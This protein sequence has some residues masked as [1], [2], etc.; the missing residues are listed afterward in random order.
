MQ[1]KYDWPEQIPDEIIREEFANAAEV[2]FSARQFNSV[3]HR[4]IGFG[5][6]GWWLPLSRVLPLVGIT[7][8]MLRPV[9]NLQYKSMRAGLQP[10][11]ETYEQLGSFP[12]SNEPFQELARILGK[13]VKVW[14]EDSGTGEHTF[15]F[16]VHPSS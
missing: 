10:V 15:V 16:T 5:D 4:A 8:Q 13:T 1:Q 11:I 9:F 2:N 7:P 3:L 14:R 12:L 6:L